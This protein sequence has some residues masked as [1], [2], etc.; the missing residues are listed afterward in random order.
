MLLKV[1]GY[2][3]GSFKTRLRRH[4][5]LLPVRCIV[6]DQ[7]LELQ[8]KELLFVI[9]WRQP[10][11][12][13]TLHSQRTGHKEHQATAHGSTCEHRHRGEKEKKKRLL[14]RDQDKDKECLQ[15]ATKLQVA[16]NNS[17]TASRLPPSLLTSSPHLPA[18]SLARFDIQIPSPLLATHNQSPFS[19][20]S[21]I[22]QSI[23]KTHT[24]PQQRN[25]STGPLRRAVIE[26]RPSDL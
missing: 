23:K 16:L 19:T 10:W 13:Q 24:K 5:Q 1:Q 7:S 21:T 8:S 11:H 9:K 18:R 26:S 20:R 25:Q 17:I 14:R 15:R 4:V 6:R 12:H 2:F 3:P 22:N